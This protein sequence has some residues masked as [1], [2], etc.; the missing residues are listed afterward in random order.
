MLT[1]PNG[2]EIWQ[3]G[4]PKNIQWTYGSIT[5][6]KIEYTTDDG[7]SWSTLTSSTPAATGQYTW[8][9]PGTY[10][11]LCRVKISDASDPSLYDISN[12]VFTINSLALAQPNGGENWQIGTTRNI[13]WTYSY[14]NNVKIEYTTNNGT[15]WLEVISSMPA[16][17]GQY[18]WTV[19]NTPSDQC[20]VKIS[21]AANSSVSDIS[22]AVFKIELRQ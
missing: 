21:D 9:I 10:S 22:D 12:A 7:G 20:R 14:I 18:V 17:T 1:Q 4:T 5:N 3:A 2:G 19:P 8:T 13:Q 15:T 11:T 16:T 6:V